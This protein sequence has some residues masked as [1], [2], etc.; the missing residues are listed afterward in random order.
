MGD[1]THVASEAINAYR[2]VKS[3]G[4]EEYE[5]NRF[6]KASENNRIQNLKLEATNAIASQRVQKFL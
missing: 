5:N 4:G 3:F 1:V 6:L 2:E